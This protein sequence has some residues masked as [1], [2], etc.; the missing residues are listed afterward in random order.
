MSMQLLI[1]NYRV[2][3]AGIFQMNVDK[4]FNQENHE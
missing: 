2:E 3:R 1:I 4:S